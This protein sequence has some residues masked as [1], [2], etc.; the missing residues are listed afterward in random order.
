[1]KNSRRP[2]CVLILVLSLGALGCSS[3]S[4]TRRTL[5]EPDSYVFMKAFRGG[6]FPT[7]LRIVDWGDTRIHISV[8]DDELRQR[9]GELSRPE[10]ERITAQLRSLHALE[11]D[12]F[13]DVP[14]SD[15]DGYRIDIRIGGKRNRIRVY[16]PW[17]SASD[18]LP[19]SKPHAAL[20]TKLL[21]LTKMD[22]LRWDVC[23]YSFHPD[24]RLVNTDGA[25]VEDVFFAKDG[26][27]M[28]ATTEYHNSEGVATD[29]D[30]D[31]VIWHSADGGDASFRLPCDLD[32]LPGHWESVP[33]FKRPTILEDASV[34]KLPSLED[35]D[36]F[37]L[38]QPRVLCG[39]RIGVYVEFRYGTQ[40]VACFI[41]N[42]TRTWPIVRLDDVDVDSQKIDLAP[43]GSR[44]AW[45][46]KGRLFVTEHVLTDCVVLSRRLKPCCD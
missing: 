37:A 43:D 20:V 26:E 4:M 23:T 9:V 13:T 1:M 25:Y 24:R 29:E 12:S 39:G 17:A 18:N 41:D 22:N 33:L 16:C 45:I 6:D 28:Y 31:W 10:Y 21:D 40:L 8:T 3:N 32:D 38:V 44:A 36:L 2:C 19:G 7:I 5:I 15:A 27:L 11:L 35:R 42:P 30:P 34:S 46:D 14:V